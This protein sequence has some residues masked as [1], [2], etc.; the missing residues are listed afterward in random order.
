[1][2]NPQLLLL[3]I[4]IILKHTI[5]DTPNIILKRSVYIRMYKP[6]ILNNIHTQ[7]QVDKNGNVKGKFGKILKPNTATKGY[8]MVKLYL[9]DGSKFNAAVHRLVAEAF[10]PNP[11]NKPEVNHKNIH[12]L[13]PAENKKDNCVE[14]LEWV[15][16]SENVKH[17]FRNK[18]R[19]A[20]YGENH[21][22]SKFEDDIIHSICKLYVQGYKPKDIRKQLNI[23]NK[24]IINRVLKGKTRLRISSQYGIVPYEIQKKKKN[25]SNSSTTNENAYLDGYYNIIIN[26]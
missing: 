11:D 10:I 13:S 7:Y 25:K 15:T 8:Q 3:L 5:I 26:A 23:Q 24:E 18:L 21:P 20:K 16:G 17:A 19:E 2:D 14:N 6:V 12:N 1:M 4:N 9:D 22:M